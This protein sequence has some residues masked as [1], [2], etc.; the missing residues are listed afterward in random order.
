MLTRLAAGEFRRRL[1]RLAGGVVA[2][3]VLFWL[4]LGSA[5]WRLRLG[6]A[7]VRQEV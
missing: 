5:D 7:G 3:G 1:T 2:I 6:G 4:G